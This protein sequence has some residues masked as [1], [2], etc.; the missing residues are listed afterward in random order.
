MVD[1]LFS[2]MARQGLEDIQIICT[3]NLPEVPPRVEA[4]PFPIKIIQN[5]RPKGFGANHNAAFQHAQGEFFCVLNP[6]IR[7]T[8][9]PFPALIEALASWPNAAVI[10]PLVMTPDGQLEDSA[11]CF[12]TPWAIF[13][14]LAGV[15][16][17]RDALA[18]RIH[19]DPA[20]VD[21]LAGMFMLFPK[22][23][24]AKMGGFDEGYFMYYEDV[25][26]CSR[27]RIAGYERLI[28][29]SV[30]VIHDARR[31][32]HRSLKFLYWHVSSMLRFFILHAWRGIIHH[33]HRR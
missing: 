32:S 22:T 5:A 17:D 31:Q 25:D 2:S 19:R 1:E 11:R 10:A 26:L 23:A 27:L 9:N 18:K 4:C 24:F 7:F 6:D 3:L 30:A 8:C 13:L 20:P 28:S 15:N 16:P 33:A 29:T 12:P 14:K 21:W